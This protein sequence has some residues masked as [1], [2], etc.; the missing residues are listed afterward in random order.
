MSCEPEWDGSEKGLIF[1]LIFVELITHIKSNKIGDVQCGA[2]YGAR[3][4]LRIVVHRLPLST[5]VTPTFSPSSPPRH[6]DTR[7]PCF[8]AD[9]LIRFG[10]SIKCELKAI[11]L[12]DLN[13][14]PFGN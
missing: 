14:S 13:S 12:D 6:P 8:S 11:S 9:G 5:S 4:N 2:S 10:S 1:P 3:F 7:H